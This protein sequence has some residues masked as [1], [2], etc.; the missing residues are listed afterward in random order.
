MLNSSRLKGI[1][2]GLAA[3]SFWGSTYPV[4]RFLL[5]HKLEHVNPIYVSF[6]IT[7]ISFICMIPLL[8][9]AQGQTELKRHWR[10]DWKLFL[11]LAVS[12]LLES[13]L[14]VASTKYTTAARS[15]LMAN[16]SPIF[17][18]LIAFFVVKETLSQNKIAGMLLGFGGISLATLSRGTDLFTHGS[19]TLTGDLLALA[20]GF[21][22][23]LY[24]VAAGKTASRNYGSMFICGIVSG[25]RI[26][27]LIPILW[28]LQ[29][30]ISLDLPL[31]GWLGLLYLGIF[32]GILATC[33]WYQALKHLAPGELGS[34]GYFSATLATLISAIFLQ[35]R[36]SWLFLLAIPCVLFGISL[37]LR[38]DSKK[39]CGQLYS[40][41]E[42][43]H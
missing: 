23:G 33:C 1:F 29:C 32:P 14:V 20:S 13:L 4:G 5:G 39:E 43:C 28:L 2:F 7:C 6:L 15:S 30:W 40:K 18:A 3:T 27:L 16:T 9:S 17:T 38:T 34:F 41:P 35:E 22:W 42:K 24:T 10:T 19:G 11:F 37:M 36:F 31:A 21:C 26:L 8:F 25:L 12:A